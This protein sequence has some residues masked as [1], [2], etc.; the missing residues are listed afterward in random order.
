LY[1]HLV[2]QGEKSQDRKTRTEQAEKEKKVIGRTG[3]A[4]KIGR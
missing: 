1:S 3:Q 2:Q 4:D